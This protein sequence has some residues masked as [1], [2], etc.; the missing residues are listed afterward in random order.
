MR[1]L[2]R[3]AVAVLVIALPALVR[4]QTQA[5]DSPPTPAPA[6]AAGELALDASKKALAPITYANLT[7]L[8]VVSTAAAAAP[9]YLVLDEGMKSGKVRVIESGDGGT[10][11]E[12][13]LHNRADQP[14]FLM[15]GEVI[16]G[17]KQDRII[18]K[19]TVI[20]AKSRQ[21]IPVFC[22]EHGRWSGRKAEFSTA[23]T[24]AHTELRKKAKYADQA[25]V[26][27]EVESKNAKRRVEN[28]TDT[29]RRVATDRSV[30]RAIAEYED[31][32]GKAMRALA[33]RK[34]MVGFVVALNGEVVAIE[35]FGSPTLFRKLEDKLLRSY[36]VEAVDRPAEPGQAAK[37]LTAGE[38]QE[39]R[40]KSGR[41]KQTKAK[42]VLEGQRSKTVQFDDEDLQ[43][44]TVE[45]AEAAEP[46]YDSVFKK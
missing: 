17:G 9:S 33:G 36:Y 43:G 12:L 35:T 34:D 18:G 24:L 22:V 28:Q 30:K 10:V 11:N 23:Q 44:S 19:D 39:F 8:P 20:P 31:H 1:R 6:A 26:W 25:Q 5:A 14:L 37:P 32:F 13:V 15:A 4:A 21:A 3:F 46:V 29:Y 40:S 16:I 42:T 2:P 7:I 38:V 27:S 41:A 45:E